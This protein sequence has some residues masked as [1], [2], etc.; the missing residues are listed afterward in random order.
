MKLIIQFFLLYFICIPISSATN[1]SQSG[2]ASAH[3]LATKA[4]IEMLKQGGNA[5]DAAVAVSAVLSVVEPYSSGLGGG[6]FWLLHTKKNNRSIMIDGR[7]KAPV[8]STTNMYL[9]KKGNFNNKLSISGAL[10]SGIPGVPAALTHISRKYGRLPLS[11]TLKPAI[12]L[13]TNG[14][15]V[16]EKYRLFARLRINALRNDTEASRI[17]LLDNDVP[18][19][20]HRLKQPDLAKTLKNIADKGIEGFY[21]GNV[22]KQLVDGVRAGN[23]IWTMSDLIKYS[24]KERP[25]ITFSYKNLKI[26]SASPPSSG[27][28]ALA[29]MLGILEH[30][31]IDALDSSSQKHIIIEAMRRAYADRAVYLGD[32]EFTII[33]SKKLTSKSYIQNLTTNLNKKKATPS[34][35]ISN[36]AI[37]SGNGTDTTHYS[38]IDNE[39]NM[40]AATLSINYPFGACFVPP[41]TGVLL[42]DEMDDFS[43]KPGTPNAYGLVGGKANAIAPQ[44]RPLS[45]MSPTFIE[46]ENR[47]AVVGTPGGSR[48]ITMV[49]HAILDFSHGMDAK[50]IVTNKRYH[51]Q[52]LPDMIMFEN[53]ALTN[54]EIKQLEKMGH[55][56]NKKTS[57]YGDGQG[58][59][60]NMQIVI[61]D[62][63]SKKITAASDPRGLGESMVH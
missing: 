18:P 45:S 48:I 43:A 49:L 34:K 2:I 36:A 41:G 42:N 17:F 63:K 59:Y 21:S 27:G 4:G 62:K 39:G 12:S 15:R 1:N 19:I 40:V 37:P 61:Q 30:Y 60:G 53:G 31:K 26:T 29:E 9:D 44:K 35:Q 58:S 11:I 7:E 32:P 8:N 20:N 46:S 51:H 22:A 5:F 50:T 52:Y 24:I 28:I 55:K 23:G 14:F 25:P 10:A 16:D 13:A 57:P 33:P 3:P 56:L 38:I 54:N 6:G 47:I